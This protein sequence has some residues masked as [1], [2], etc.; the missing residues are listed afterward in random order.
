M[1]FTDAQI[2]QLIEEIYSG[3]VTE[4]DLPE[5]LY[6][7][8]ADYLKQALY[9]GYGQTLVEASGKDLEL[10]TQLRENIYMFS[11]AKVFTEVKDV[12]SLFVNDAGEL[13]TKSEFKDAALEVLGTY[14][15]DW[16]NT[17]YNTTI[18]EAQMASKWNEIEKNKDV[19][20]ILVY[21]T[22]GDACDIC[23]PLDGLT[24]EVDDP[25]WD[26]CSPLQHYNCE[27]VLLQQE[28][29]YISESENE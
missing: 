14:N 1:E 29:D 6:L 3:T 15:D 18:G 22:I 27:C 4:F 7:A 2:S 20:P 10:L 25:V 21:S 23:E 9:Q 13:R 16:L 5:S 12:S 28:G 19:L 17:E 24:A 11:A 8:I 26:D